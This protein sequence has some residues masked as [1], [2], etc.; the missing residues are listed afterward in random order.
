MNDNTT[1]H[2]TASG[3]TVGRIE[4]THSEPYQPRHIARGVHPKQNRRKAPTNQPTGFRRINHPRLTP[5]RLH[6][7]NLEKKLAF[8]I[9]GTISI[10]LFILAFI[11]SGAEQPYQQVL[12]L[13][14]M[15]AALLPPKAYELT[16]GDLPE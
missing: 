2:R 7:G 4:T 12:A 1:H 13:P 14:L 5:R 16:Y 15:L 11:I 8:Y 6:A 3:R 9:A 10:T